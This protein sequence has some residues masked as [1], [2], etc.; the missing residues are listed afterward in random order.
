M[1]NTLWFLVHGSTSCQIL[2]PF[3]TEGTKEVPELT[4]TQLQYWFGLR[5]RRQP[6]F[7]NDE[8]GCLVYIYICIYVGYVGY[9]VTDSGIFFAFYKASHT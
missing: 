1:P 6:K 7:L 9:P 3:H 8:S 4:E 5:A 2:Q